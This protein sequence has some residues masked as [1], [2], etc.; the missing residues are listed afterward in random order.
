MIAAI[1]SS[2]RAQSERHYDEPSSLGPRPLRKQWLY[3]HLQQL[4]AACLVKRYIHLQEAFRRV[5][6][7]RDRT[8]TAVMRRRRPGRGFFFSRRSESCRSAASTK[9]LVVSPLDAHSSMPCFSRVVVRNNRPSS[10]RDGLFHRH[11]RTTIY[12]WTEASSSTRMCRKE[13]KTRKAQ[14][15]QTRNVTSTARRPLKFKEIYNEVRTHT[16]SRQNKYIFKILPF[17]ITKKPSK[18]A[19]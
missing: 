3:D 14:N 8:A 2:D 5:P 18:Y 16:F 10:G 13:A 6:K 7:S 19:L 9:G 15:G 4:T 11:R 1:S 17:E 12:L